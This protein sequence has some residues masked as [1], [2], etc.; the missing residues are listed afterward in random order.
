MLIYDV[1]LFQFAVPVAV[2]ILCVFIV[3]AFGFKSPGTPPTLDVHDDE[4]RLQK[5][6]KSGGK[7][8]GKTTD[9]PVTTSV[10]QPFVAPKALNNIHSNIKVNVVPSSV[11]KPQNEQPKVK[12]KKPAPK[13]VDENANISYTS[14]EV[15]DWTTAVS[16]K[17]RKNQAKKKEGEPLL[18]LK[19]SKEVVKEVKEQ[20]VKKVEAEKL[21]AKEVVPPVESLVDVAEEAEFTEVVKQKKKQKNKKVDKVEEH[22]PSSESTIV[23][24]AQVEPVAVDVAKSCIATPKMV[25]EVVETAKVVDEV[26]EAVKAVNE[27][28]DE[29]KMEVVKSKKKK[30]PETRKNF[31]EVPLQ[32]SEVEAENGDLNMVQVHSSTVT[33]S[34]TKSQKVKKEDGKV[35]KAAN[36]P[37]EVLSTLPGGSSAPV[38]LREAELATSEQ[39]LRPV[40]DDQGEWQQAKP[41]KRKRQVQRE[42]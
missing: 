39:P 31:Q 10:K 6:K 41:V 21:E 32:S 1:P 37:R 22:V 17:N 9:A 7:K 26:V 24:E 34:K 20:I 28:T 5:P 18:D 11:E 42:H 8:S 33:S 3:F 23:E 30:R 36:P 27:A 29:G 12:A 15:G 4:E 35:E 14:E 19:V 40:S 38:A 2:V 16:K 25:E 13:K